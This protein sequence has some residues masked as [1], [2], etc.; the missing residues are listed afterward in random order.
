MGAWPFGPSLPSSVLVSFGLSSKFKQA[1]GYFRVPR[2]RPMPKASNNWRIAFCYIQAAKMSIMKA[3][4][5]QDVIGS[6]W[7]TFLRLSKFGKCEHVFWRLSVSNA[8]RMSQSRWRWQYFPKLF[9][10][11]IFFVFMPL[12]ILGPQ[13]SLECDWATLP[14]EIVYLPFHTPTA[15]LLTGQS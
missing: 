2:P 8:L 12:T 9:V 5:L 10:H 13:G 15:G 3:S 7:K 11:R 6:P 1:C 14:S 4:I